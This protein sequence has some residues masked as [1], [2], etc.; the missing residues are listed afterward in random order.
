V[1]S[2]AD[3]PLVVG[4][5]NLLAHHFRDVY[6]FHVPAQADPQQVHHCTLCLNPTLLHTESSTT[7]K[8]GA[9]RVGRL[10]G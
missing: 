2:I 5:F 3:V 9:P 8:P 6:G 7:G 1:Y 10:E 4:L